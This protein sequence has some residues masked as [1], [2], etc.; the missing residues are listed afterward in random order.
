MQKL[1]KSTLCHQHCRRVP[2]YQAQQVC[3][4]EAPQGTCS[5]V[6][7]Q[8]C[9]VSSH[10]I[11]FGCRNQGS[12]QTSVHARA[13]S[14]ESGKPTHLQ[15]AEG[16]DGSCPAV[17]VLP[18]PVNLVTSLDTLASMPADTQERGREF[19]SEF[20]QLLGPQTS[21]YSANGGKPK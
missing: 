6:V 5:I 1:C 17:G 4:Q 20:A 7:S 21:R 8:A 2:S 13:C 19:G 9:S 18:V 15:P 16:T 3:H 12:R 14:L 10:C 11:S